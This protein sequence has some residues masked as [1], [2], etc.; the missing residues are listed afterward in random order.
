LIIVA[1]TFRIDAGQL[2]ALRPHAV[3]V[4]E[5]TRAEAGCQVY[6]F[7]EDLTDP[8]LIRIFEIWDSR[9]H[10]DAH[11]RAPH[12]QPWRAA[13]VQLG[14]RD[15]KLETFDTAGGTPL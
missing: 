13:L 10:L 15:R 6:S 1:G 7:A 11:G 3:A 4:I 5:A 8:G 9:E 14:A 2:G 12:M